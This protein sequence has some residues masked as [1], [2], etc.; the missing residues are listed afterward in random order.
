MN[1]KIVDI[2]SVERE[3]QD[4]ITRF[5][6]YSNTIESNKSL[7]N[8]FDAMLTIIKA[9]Y[10]IILQLKNSYNMNSYMNV[11]SNL[12]VLLLSHI[13]TQ[14]FNAMQILSKK[15]HMPINMIINELMTDVVTNADVKGT[16]LGT[17]QVNVESLK[18][19]LIRRKIEI[20]LSN[21]DFVEVMNQDITDPQISCNFRDIEILIFKNVG[22]EE[23]QSSIGKIQHCKTVFLPSYIPK[24]L[25]YSKIQNVETIK[26]YESLHDVYDAIFVFN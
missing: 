19:K 10:D 23:F 2:R 20:T 8:Q 17:P 24:L 25:I 15:L 9:Y 21:K 3:L 5:T 12:G 22:V 26:I 1:L 13:S 16:G 7:K 4:Q 11:E 6:A 18:Q 14:T